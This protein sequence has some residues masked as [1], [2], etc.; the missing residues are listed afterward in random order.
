MTGSS[1]R[2]D[3]D[4]DLPVALALLR[5]ILKAPLAADE[6]RWLVLDADIVFGLGL[7]RVWSEAEA[8]GVTPGEITVLVEARDAARAARDWARADSTARRARRPRLG[9]R[10]WARRLDGP[11]AGLTERLSRRSAGPVGHRTGR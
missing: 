3:D 7:D 10:G 5:E 2:I 8:G 9:G 1:P 6:R 11:P 4:L